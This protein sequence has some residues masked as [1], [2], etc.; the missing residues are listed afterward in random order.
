[1]RF[2]SSMF[3]WNCA[4]CWKRFVRNI[5]ISYF[6]AVFI[7]FF[8]LSM[9]CT[10]KARTVRPFFVWLLVLLLFHSKLMYLVLLYCFRGCIRLMDSILHNVVHC[11][12]DLRVF[13]CDW[14]EYFTNRKI[15]VKKTC[16]KIWPI[17]F[18]TLFSS[19]KCFA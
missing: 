12:F 9:Y 18:V 16:F 15:H 1:M 13:H 8:F 2:F 11:M 17:N 10:L 4:C 6:F 19:G 3:K 7:S 14:I 5:M